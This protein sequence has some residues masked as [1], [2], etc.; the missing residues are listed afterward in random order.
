MNL[1]EN[2]VR[3]LGAFGEIVI[4]QERQGANR[5]QGLHDLEDQGP[6]VAENPAHFLFMRAGC[7]CVESC[8]ALP[9][10]DGVD[11][12]KNSDEIKPDVEI[13]NLE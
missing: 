5:Q 7:R 6:P 13:V 12:A 1:A 8:C 2:L 3:R 9:G 11:A 10:H 4:D